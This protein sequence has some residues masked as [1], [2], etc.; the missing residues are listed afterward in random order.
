MIE[1]DMLARHVTNFPIAPGNMP[2]LLDHATAFENI[3][4]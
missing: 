2:D 1:T 4:A 3:A